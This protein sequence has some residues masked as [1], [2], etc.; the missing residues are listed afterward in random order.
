MVKKRKHSHVKYEKSA[1]KASGYDEEIDGF[2]LEDD[3][4]DLFDEAEKQDGAK[5][6]ALDDSWAWEELDDEQPT[7]IIYFDFDRVN[8]KNDQGPIVRHNAELAKLACEDGGDS[9]Y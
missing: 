8:I 1:G 5:K 6:D 3:D 7:E 2:V 9:Y 4:Y